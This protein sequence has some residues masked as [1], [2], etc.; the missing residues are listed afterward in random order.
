MKRR[1]PW[2]SL[3]FLEQKGWSAESIDRKVY[4]YN[5]IYIFVQLRFL[6]DH[7]PNEAKLLKE[8][9]HK[10]KRETCPA[11]QRSLGGAQLN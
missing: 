9:G 1:Q 4:I 2:I 6:R 11:Q 10:R 7:L 5:Y 3:N 8:T